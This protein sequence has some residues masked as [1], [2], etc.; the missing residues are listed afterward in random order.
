MTEGAYS[1]ALQAYPSLALTVEALTC[2]RGER[3]V[4]SSLGFSVGTGQ[5]LFVTG[6]NG[7]G[8]TSL[9][10]TLAGLLRPAAGTIN[11]IGHDPDEP[12]RQFLHHVGH[13]GAVKPALTVAENIA[14]WRQVYGGGDRQEEA[15]ADA[16]LGELARYPAAILSAG[17]TRRLALARLSAVPRPVWLLDEPTASL[18]AGGEDWVRRL[19]ATHLDAGGLAIVASHRP[20]ELAEPGRAATLA[21]APERDR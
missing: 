17:Q 2:R 12:V 3:E 14:F 5:A 19:I 1:S 13:Q 21:L 9:L 4:F 20:A 16:G 11:W 18:D 6:R 8:K 10:A 7:A 15:L